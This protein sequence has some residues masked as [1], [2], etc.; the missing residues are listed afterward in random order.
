MK[1][2]LFVAATAA[3]WM[4]ACSQNEMFEDQSANSAIEF[5]AYTN[6]A[7]R[8]S[9]SLVSGNEFPTNGEMGVFAYYTANEA[10][11]G[12]KTP[13]FMFNQKV[14]KTDGSYTYSPIKYWPN[15]ANDKITFFAY[16]PHTATDLTWK[17]HANPTASSYINTSTNLPV[18]DFTV[19]NK[20]TD[21]IDFMYAIV[22]DQTKTA[23]TVK[24]TFN[25]ALTQVNLKAKLG[26][27]LATDNKT[28]VTITKI[29]FINI[30]KNGK[31][32]MAKSSL[33]WEGTSNSGDFEAALSDENGVKITSTT[34]AEVTAAS[35][36]FLMMPQTLQNNAG[37]EVTYKVK[38]EDTVLD[39]GAS[40]ITNT[41]TSKISGNWEPNNN[42]VYTI[43]I[44]L[45]KVEVDAEVTE[46]TTP[47]TE[48]TLQPINS[49]N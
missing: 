12:A 30:Y 14:T 26:A 24:F 48:G 13:N 16:Y 36:T 9:S 46:W 29:K 10:W 31:L 41:V 37:I 45:T 7:T 42:I 11:S 43:T 27:A 32:D 40:E 4:S 8:A 1:N 47:Q 5:G 33:S 49:P 22:K 3:I 18:A 21:Q 2:I 6:L 23:G 19:Q 35:E 17:D 34:A 39:G 28:T 38:T 15:N 20:A 44:G 25:H